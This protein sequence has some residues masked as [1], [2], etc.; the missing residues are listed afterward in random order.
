MICLPLPST[1]LIVQGDLTIE[2]HNDERGRSHRRRF[3]ISTAPGADKEKP[4]GPGI[5]YEGSSRN[6]CQFVEGHRHLSPASAERFIARGTLRVVRVPSASASASASA[7]EVWS[8]PDEAKLKSWLRS[9]KF[10]P[11]GKAEPRWWWD[12]EPKIVEFSGEKPASKSE[13][14][15][16]REI[17]RWFEREWKGVTPVKVDAGVGFGDMVLCSVLIII[18]CVF[19]GVF[20][21][22]LR[23]A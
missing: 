21:R 19:L 11:G 17:A 15:A 3:E 13:R 5:R 22:A 12:C 20:L 1:H 23:T 14:L 10:R 16:Q 2:S 6:G 9:A 4:V 18:L 7:S 8:L